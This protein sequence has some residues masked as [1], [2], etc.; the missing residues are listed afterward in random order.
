MKRRRVEA[1]KRVASRYDAALLGVASLGVDRLTTRV[2]RPVRH[3][4]RHARTQDA[5]RE[6]SSSSRS[7]RVDSHQPPATC[8]NV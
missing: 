3:S 8:S 5:R 2:L 7:E 6:D 4:A 1:R